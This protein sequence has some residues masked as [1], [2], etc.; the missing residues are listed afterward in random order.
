[1]KHEAIQ[2]AAERVS[3][4]LEQFTEELDDLEDWPSEDQRFDLVMMALVAIARR[5]GVARAF[6]VMDKLNSST[7]TTDRQWRQEDSD[8]HAMLMLSET[9]DELCE[10]R[11]SGLVT[12]V[13]LAHPDTQE[14]LREAIPELCSGVL[15]GNPFRG[16]AH[17]RGG[18]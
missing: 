6:E 15:D 9:I 7:V 4:A 10:Q 14:R 1:M 13:R 5:A 3:E 17:L 16:S 12:M 11:G 8:F 2:R 18:K